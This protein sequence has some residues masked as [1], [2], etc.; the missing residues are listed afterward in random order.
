M[1]KNKNKYLT[2]LASC[3]VIALLCTTT[4]PIT[5]EAA[6]SNLAFNKNFIISDQTFTSFRDFPNVEAVQKFLNSKKSILANYK[7]EN[8]SAADIIF[9]SANGV[10]STKYGVKP[11][12]SP[13]L[14]L[15]TLEKE[16]S[17]VTTTNYDIAKDPESRIKTAMGYGCPDTAK[18]NPD[19]MGF[20]NQVTWAAY[21]LQA[22]F[23][24]AKAQNPKYS[25]YL[26]NSTIKTSDNYSVTL[27]NAATA[28]LYRYTPH[29][30]WGNYN[31]FKIMVHNGWTV[32]K[33]VASYKEI[34]DANKS[35][36]D[37]GVCP[38]LMLQKFKYGTTNDRNK[39]LQKCLQKSGFFYFPTITG[40]FGDVTKRGMIDYLSSN[41]ACERFYY[42][43]F[44]IGTVSPEISQLQNCLIKEKL[45]PLAKST[46][47]YGPI[48]N[49]ALTTYKM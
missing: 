13:A 43:S 7:T 37:M 16:Q 41:G 19:Y 23:T 1:L 15:A 26:I 27:D 45:F 42:K 24:G 17:L 3:L 36:L 12:I 49:K 10:L 30:F 40:Y 20:Y 31:L 5:T 11:S 14:I 25:P 9:N 44:N 39:N 48:T 35:I 29:V 32:N 18:C 22:N 33:T 34:D 6:N 21:Q 38:T 4:L 2:F 8:R 28:S 47:Y 46:G